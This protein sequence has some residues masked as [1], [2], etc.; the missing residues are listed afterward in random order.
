MDR[1]SHIGRSDWNCLRQY[2]Q[3]KGRGGG[4]AIVCLKGEECGGKT[5]WDGR[6]NKGGASWEVFSTDVSE[7]PKETRNH[8]MATSC[9]G[10]DQG[11]SSLEKNLVKLTTQGGKVL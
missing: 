2:P 5:V 1:G 10:G 4:S 9:G 7:E 6:R 3:K 11:S 8:R